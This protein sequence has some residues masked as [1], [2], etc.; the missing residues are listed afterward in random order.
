MTNE[1]L[2]EHCAACFALGILQGAIM[3]S[4]SDK[5]TAFALGKYVNTVYERLIDV[6]M[7]GENADQ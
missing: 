6:V 2:K 5:T 1:E 4:V 3:V 7:E